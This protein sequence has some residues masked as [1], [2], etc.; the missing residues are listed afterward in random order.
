MNCVIGCSTCMVPTLLCYKFS[1]WPSSR[2]IKW[3][4]SF[5]LLWTSNSVYQFVLY[6]LWLIWDQLC[7]GCNQGQLEKKCKDTKHLLLPVVISKWT[8]MYIY[9]IVTYFSLFF[10]PSVSNRRRCWWKWERNCWYRNEENG[11]LLFWSFLK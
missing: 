7:I 1:N 3:F 4:F 2:V 5:V 6:F 11:K 9:V 8:Y 10:V